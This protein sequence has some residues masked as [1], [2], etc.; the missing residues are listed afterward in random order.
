MPD[1]KPVES[2]D[3]VAKTDAL[4]WQRQQLR[5]KAEL[6][7]VLDERAMTDKGLRTISEDR[8]RAVEERDE[9]PGS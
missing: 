8:N 7:K 1:N 4:K 5:K 6:N 9:V 2:F 3:D